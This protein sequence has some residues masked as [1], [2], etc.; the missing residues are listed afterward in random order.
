MLLFLPLWE[1]KF[2]K[3][4]SEFGAKV[5]ILSQLYNNMLVL[6]SLCILRSDKL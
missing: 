5:E 2:L 1:V 6:N 3:H 4:L